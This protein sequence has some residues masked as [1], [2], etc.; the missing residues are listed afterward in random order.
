MT[1]TC[2][3]TFVTVPVVYFSFNTVYVHHYLKS[4]KN[5]GLQFRKYLMENGHERYDL[6]ALERRAILTNHHQRTTFCGVTYS[7]EMAIF[8][9]IKEY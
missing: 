4:A 7:K 9:Q 6:L 3:L 1:R 8:N 5:Q 2:M